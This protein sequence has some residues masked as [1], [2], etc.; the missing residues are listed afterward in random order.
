MTDHRCKECKKDWTK[1]SRCPVMMKWVKSIK[2]RNDMEAYKIT[3]ELN[4]E[5]IISEARE[6]AQ[7]FNKFADDLEQIEKKYA[8]PQNLKYADNDALKYADNDTMMPAT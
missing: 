3:A 4:L 2:V 5:K 7:V 1:C 6:V 8:D